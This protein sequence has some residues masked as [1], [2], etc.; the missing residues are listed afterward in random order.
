M[1]ILLKEAKTPDVFIFD[2]FWLSKIMKLPTCQKWAVLNN[3]LRY[4]FYLCFGVLLIIGNK[5]QRPPAE[6]QF[7]SFHLDRY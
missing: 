2:Y 4:S 1:F 3:Q 6:I 5:P 7:K